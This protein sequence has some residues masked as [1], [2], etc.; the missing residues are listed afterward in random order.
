MTAYYDE[1]RISEEVEQIL[2]T[3]EKIDPIRIILLG[4]PDEVPEP[5]GFRPLEEMIHYEKS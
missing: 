3:P 2:N 5:K 1:T 4:Y